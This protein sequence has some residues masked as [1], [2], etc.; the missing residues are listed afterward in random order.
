MLIKAVQEQQLQILLGTKVD[1]TP[2][3]NSLTSSFVDKADDS[4]QLLPVYLGSVMSCLSNKIHEQTKRLPG[5][6]QECISDGL[7]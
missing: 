4:R 3:F 1:K 7:G 5:R 6:Q 2:E